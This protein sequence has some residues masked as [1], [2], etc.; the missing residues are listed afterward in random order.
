M[1]KVIKFY[2]P[3]S[4]RK[5]LRVA[6]PDPGKVLEFCSSPKPSVPA[7]PAGGVIEW[8]LGPEESNRPAS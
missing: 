4:L 7:R 1:A 2:V 6:Q 8:L 3:K 5:A